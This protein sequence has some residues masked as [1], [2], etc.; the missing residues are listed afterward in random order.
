MTRM[1][2]MNLT[3]NCSEDDWRL[4]INCCEIA[5]LLLQKEKNK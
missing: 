3:G 2:E 1:L 5:L 4:F